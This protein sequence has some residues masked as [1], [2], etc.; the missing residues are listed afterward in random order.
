MVS[1]LGNDVET[2]WQAMMNSECGVEPITRFDTTNFPCTIAAFVKD[3]DPQDYLDRRDA[4]R[5]AP[6]LHF[7]VAATHQAVADAGLDFS[8]EDPTRV[9]IEI[10]RI[11]F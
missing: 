11:E 10:G 6:F 1:P 5:M 3:F 2:T 8:L 9:G 7:A 4:R